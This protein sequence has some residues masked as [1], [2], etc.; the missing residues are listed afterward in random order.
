MAGQSQK[1]LDKLMKKSEELFFKYGYTGISVDQIAAEAGISKMTLYKHF[2]SKEDLLVEVLIR[3]I[4]YHFK[5][6]ME[7]INENYHTIDKIE[8]LYTYTL[9]LSQQFPPI[10]TKDVFK[11]PNLMERIGNYKIK[12]VKGMWKSILE[13]GIEKEEIRPLDVD[14]VCELLIVLPYAFVDTDYFKDEEKISELMKK[15]YDFMKYGMLGSMN[16]QQYKDIKEGGEN[17]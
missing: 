1:K 6:I 11:Y 16:P 3:F 17:A 2:N 5:I 10:L 7:K 12:L 9:Q 4:E 8:A 13:D 14:F 15:L